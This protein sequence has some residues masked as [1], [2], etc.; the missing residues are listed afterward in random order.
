M[1]RHEHLLR[2]LYQCSG[3]RGPQREG[4]LSWAVR[5]LDTLVV[6]RTGGGKTAM[7]AFAAGTGARGPDH[8]SSSCFVLVLRNIRTVA[9]HSHIDGRK[10]GMQDDLWQ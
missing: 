8:P 1:R 2:R 3:F 5:E 7:F 4:I 9:L 10:P 6:W